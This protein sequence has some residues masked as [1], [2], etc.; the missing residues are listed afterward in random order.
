VLTVPQFAGSYLV[1]WTVV[2]LVAYALY[3]PH[4]MV[5]ALV[6]PRNY[7]NERRKRK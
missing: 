5:V 2:G 4:G 1:V 6:D 3:R 7:M